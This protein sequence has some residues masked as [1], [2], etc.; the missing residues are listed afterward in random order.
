LLSN[1]IK[2]ILFEDLNWNKEKKGH[3]L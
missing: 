1:F 2:L 3:H